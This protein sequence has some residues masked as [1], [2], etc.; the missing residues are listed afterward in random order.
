M[1]YAFP[2]ESEE[3]SADLREYINALLLV[4]LLPLHNNFREVTVAELLNDVVVV[5]ALHHV[6][7]SH[8][9]LRDHCSKNLDL[10]SQRRH[11]IFVA[12]H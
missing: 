6:V 3:T 9:V 5:G 2:D 10:A 11:Q 7:E 4:H 12:S 8:R 1:N